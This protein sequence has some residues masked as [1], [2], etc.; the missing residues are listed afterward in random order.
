MLKRLSELETKCHN[1]GLTVV[2]KGTK[3]AKSDCIAALREHYMPEGGLAYEEIT[4][5]QCFAEWNLEDSEREAIWDSP[6]WVAQ[7]KLNGCRIILHFV[8]GVGV[9]GHSRTVSVKTFRFQDLTDKLLIR[10]FVPDF[11]A[12]VDAEALVEKSIDT[13]NYTSKGEVSETTLHSTTAILHLEAS[14]ACQIQIDQDA[15]IQFKVFDI[16][17]WE[18]RDITSLSL[19]ERLRI[20]NLFDEALEGSDLEKVFHF[21]VT[22][23]FD[24]PSF[25][26]EIIDA[27]GEGVVL[28]NLDS[29]YIASSSRSRKGWVKVK[30][31]VEFDAFVSDFQRGDPGKGWENLVGALVFSVH[32]EE[33]VH[34]IAKCSSLPL[35]L[36]TEMSTYDEG[37]DRVGI[38][39]EWI[40]R[41]AQV[42]GQEI[43]PRSYRLSHAVIDRWRFTDGA[44]FKASEDCEV[45]FGEMKEAAKWTS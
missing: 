43:M 16:M 19:S 44:D 24:K 36:R 35:D 40:G 33:G 9:F 13:R 31:R 34:E 22:C 15:A 3:L 21:P 42:S 23:Q 12:T 30:A 37:A 38:K 26:Q 27:G 7:E 11:D 41:V 29:P 25:Y 8:K 10:G 39:P 6:K 28:K 32:T 45:N 5:M 20:L 17:R 4:P 18:G 14:K 1:L 2:P